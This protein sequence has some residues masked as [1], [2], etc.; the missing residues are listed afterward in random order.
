M[1]ITDT[2]IFAL[3]LSTGVFGHVTWEESNNSSAV[4]SG[5]HNLV[6]PL[7][8]W[9]PPNLLMVYEK[10]LISLLNKNFNDLHFSLALRKY[11]HEQF[12]ALCREWHD[13]A[14]NQNGMSI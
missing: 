4:K 14:L 13:I 10:E 11:A 5:I 7:K 6:P 2:D 1:A 3:A 12:S 9:F 8:I